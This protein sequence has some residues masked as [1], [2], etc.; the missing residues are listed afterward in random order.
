MITIRQDLAD[1]STSLYSENHN[2]STTKLYKTDASE[3]HNREKDITK[4]P[5]E[6]LKN[7]LTEQNKSSTEKSD[8]N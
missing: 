7:Q 8:K 1:S 5:E 3:L 6:V 4:V 2:R